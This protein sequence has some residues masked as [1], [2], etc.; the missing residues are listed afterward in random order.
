[1]S[2]L[3]AIAFFDIPYHSRIVTTLPLVRALVE[4][5][6][7]VDGFTLEPFQKLLSSS[8][9]QVVLQPPFGPMPKDCTVNLRT[10]DYS[11]EYVRHIVAALQERKPA[12]VLLTAK[13]LWAAMAA[14]LCGIPTAVIHTNALLPR[15]SSVSDAV[16][17]AR[18]PGKSET[19]LAE[20]EQRD[21]REWERLRNHYAIS[22]I[23]DADVL[24]GLP[25]C[26]NLRGDLNVVYTS[27][28][29]Q[30][31]WQA[32]DAS[33]H[34][35][36]PCY[37]ARA[38]D[39]DAA[40]ES[41]IDRLPR[42]LI[43]C[44]LGSM[45]SYNDRRHFFQTVLSACSDGRFG[46]VMSVG[47]EEAMAAL[48]RTPA[49]VL[50]RP[51]VPQLAVLARTSLFITHAGTNSVY[52]SLLAGVPMLMCPQGGDQPIFAE[53]IESLGAGRWLHEPLL[54]A[55]TMRAAVE[56]MITDA[57]MAQQAKSLGESLRSAGGIERAADLITEFSRRA[58]ASLGPLPI[59]QGLAS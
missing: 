50:V 57:G 24:P 39:A 27:S 52:E 47:S 15:G 5:G 44:A 54:D 46:V 33:Y 11:R 41:A 20:I 17:A 23:H 49:H 1:M 26:M 58:A 16:Y 59:Q 29:L 56:S 8:G 36:G 51:Y 2:Q 42:P 28:V 22:R 21:R 43:Y 3:P 37:D 45:R 34:F 55:K 4:R 10:I 32:F 53:H 6:H 25:N 35:V 13:C 18:W 40:V 38:V 7:R 9:A 48:G 19:E 30:P 14:E 31:Q 12:I